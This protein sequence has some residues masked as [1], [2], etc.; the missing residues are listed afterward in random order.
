MVLRVD[1]AEPVLAAMREM[2]AADA[3]KPTQSKR[4]QPNVIQPP[5]LMVI[6]GDVGLHHAALWHCRS[7]FLLR[8]VH[9]A[10][11]RGKEHTCN[12]SSVL[13]SYT[14]N[15]GRVDETGL[16]HVDIFIGAGIVAEIILALTDLLDDD[17]SFDACVL[18]NHA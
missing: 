2:P 8:D 18:G 5:S 14:G 11:L 3:V 7:R 9:D 16:E 1:L 6:S 13:E 10:A 15:L 12:R 4:R 17:A